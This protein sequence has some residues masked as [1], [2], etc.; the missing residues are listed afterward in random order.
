MCLRCSV[1][2]WIQLYQYIPINCLVQIIYVFDS[3]AYSSR[4]REWELDAISCN[5]ICN[6]TCLSPIFNISF[7][8]NSFCY[9]FRH[10]VSTISCCCGCSYSSKTNV[11]GMLQ[12][13]F[14]ICHLIPHLNCGN[15][16]IYEFVFLMDVIQVKHQEH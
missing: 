1:F 12:K 9:I 14:E 4:Y 7:R 16:V 3:I 10:S 13:V 11:S 6:Q 15:F 8:T 2:L 5:K